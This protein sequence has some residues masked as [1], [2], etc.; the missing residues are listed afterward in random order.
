[1]LD[2]Q[3]IL[4]TIDKAHMLDSLIQFP[5]QIQQALELTH[6][7]QL[8]S[9]LKIDNILI[10]GM[11]ASAISGDIAQSLLY[12]KL[13]VPLYVNR[14]YDLPRWVNKDTLALFLSY[15]G[16]TEETL[17][18]F[19]LAY[20]KKA[21]II[22]ITS[23]GKL[24]EFCDTYTIPYIQIPTGFQPRAAT[25]FLLFP[26]LKILQQN[27]LIKYN[28]N[29][30][31]EE[32][33]TVTKQLGEQNH[34]E[35]PLATNS[36]KQ[37]ATQIL[38]TIPQ[39]YG[40]E[41]YAPIAIRWRHQFNENSK[42]IARADIIPECNHNDIVGWSGNS[43]MAKQFS[44]I[45]FRDKDEESIQMT[46]RLDFMKELFQDT[47]ANYIDVKP[48]GK[49]RLAKMMYLMNLGDLTSCYLAILRKVDPSPV[50]IILELKKRLAQK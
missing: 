1:M 28:I 25:A 18:S 5:H 11:G 7:T 36:A 46:K 22:C 38:N 50:D 24:K 27:N 33:V 42:I 20:Q 32:T 26:L 19:K 41:I 45:I 31:I 35:I 48:K 13:D 10:S 6:A 44:C 43:E 40:W 2:D 3:A 47:V 23:G 12:D 4:S 29:N 37:L 39:I 21:K 9:F 17:S 15:S 34:K 30:D 49:S 8:P 14:S 16:N